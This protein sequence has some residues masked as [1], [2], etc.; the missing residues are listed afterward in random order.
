MVEWWLQIL[1]FFHSFL[2]Q[3]VYSAIHYLTKPPPRQYV[4]HNANIMLVIGHEMTLTR[5]ILQYL[6]QYFPTSFSPHCTHMAP[7]LLFYRIRI[8]VLEWWNSRLCILQ[9]LKYALNQSINSLLMS[10][11]SKGDDLWKVPKVSG[12]SSTTS[13]SLPT[14]QENSSYKADTALAEIHIYRN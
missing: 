13:D 2:P 10:A 12:S 6:V 1:C 3:F 14:P 8:K 11:W 7:S 4:R 5:S 9:S